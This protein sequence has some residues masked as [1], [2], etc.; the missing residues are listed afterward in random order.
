M[1]NSN[2]I[3]FIEQW[4]NGAFETF[5]QFQDT[6]RD[7]PHFN[8]LSIAEAA[9]HLEEY[10]LYNL[11]YPHLVQSERAV[12]DV[13]KSR[14]AGD[15]SLKNSIEQAI[16]ICTSKEHRDVHLEGRL[17][18]ERGLLRFEE[19][20]FEGAESDLTWA[21]TRLKS[22]SKASK[23][24]DLSLLNKAAFHL[25]RGEQLMALQVYGDI[26]RYGGH[27]H[28]TIAIS[29]L[30]ASRIHYGLGHLFDAARHAWNAHCH[31][32]IAH[33]TL[34]AI[35]AG[36]LFIEISL[37]HQNE[38]AQKMNIQS[39][40]SVPR[41]LKSSL[42]E[43][44]VHPSDIQEV[45]IWCVQHVDR[46]LSG[47]HRPDLQALVRIALHLDE[48]DSIQ[49]LLGHPNNVEDPILAALCL[50]VATD[51]DLV[52]KWNNRLSKLSQV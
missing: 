10:V 36:T 16:Q 29:R 52:S 34:M 24:H 12:L 8:L 43:L 23:D 13:V 22:V 17:R 44:S 2:P 28:E 46:V 26:S 33:Q 45:F 14:I 35:E 30:G 20:D 3:E 6:I 40:Q 37:A 32:I 1:M 38:N 18:M 7:T 5:D 15:G 42:P 41:D 31:S 11:C 9:L 4:K 21:E 25:A 39:D 19:G 49:F 27:A 51:S 50:T 47:V 48:I